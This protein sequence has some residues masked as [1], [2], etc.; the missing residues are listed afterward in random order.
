M[1]NAKHCDEDGSGCFRSENGG[2][3][4]YSEALRERD[5]SV[6]SWA[7]NTSFIGE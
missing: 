6:N 4:D 2:S 3:T 1:L 7:I 5:V